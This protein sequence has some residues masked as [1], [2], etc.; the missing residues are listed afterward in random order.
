MATEYYGL[1]APFT[2]I[3]IIPIYDLCL[4]LVDF[5]DG[6]ACEVRCSRDNAP[7]VLCALAGQTV[8]ATRGGSGV[9]YADA[10]LP[11]SLQLVSDYGDLVTLGEVR[12][13]VAP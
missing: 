7:R 1:R 3:R 5:A 4:M 13:G 12:R 6:A 9:V 8:I 10:D 11:D 2:A